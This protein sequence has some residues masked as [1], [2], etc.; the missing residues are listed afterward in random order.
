MSG[1][2]VSKDCVSYTKHL[3]LVF[4]ANTTIFYSPEASSAKRNDTPD[5]VL[6][7]SPEKCS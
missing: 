2:P 3:M 4:V 1:S 5:A 6:V 7:H